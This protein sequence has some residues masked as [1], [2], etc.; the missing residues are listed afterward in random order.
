MNCKHQ[1][2]LR[3]NAKSWQMYFLTAQWKNDFEFE[4][5]API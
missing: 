1:Y 5:E 3:S 4:N 2:A